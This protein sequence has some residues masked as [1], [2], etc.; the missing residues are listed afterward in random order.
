MGGCE[1]R[2]TLTVSSHNLTISALV[3]TG[4]I[5]NLLQRDVF[6]KIVAQTHQISLLRPTQRIQAV[7]NTQINTVGETEIQLDFLPNPIHVIVVDGIQHQMII[8]KQ[9]LRHGAAVLD[10]G[11]NQL[12]WYGR[13]LTLQAVKTAGHAGIGLTAPRIGNP[14]IDKLVRNNADVFSSNGE[15]NGNCLLDT[16]RIN[17]NRPPICQEAYRA[18]LNK[19]HLVEECVTEM[20]RDGIIEPSTS[21]WASPIVH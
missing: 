5:C 14:D 2:A 10:L 7:N 20:L 11:K 8:G 13:N 6:N 18:H 4:A 3:D 16:L 15:P 19:R 12:S 17:A 1:G 21:A 9:T